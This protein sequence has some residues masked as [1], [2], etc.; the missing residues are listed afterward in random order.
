[1]YLYGVKFLLVTDHKPLVYIFDKNKKIPE[2]TNNRISGYAVTLMMYNY[3]IKYGNTKEHANCDM[4]SRLPAPMKE[5]SDTISEY[6][7]VFAVTLEE[8]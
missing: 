7:A 4:L 3:E 8:A 1:M 2:M 5:P 6:D